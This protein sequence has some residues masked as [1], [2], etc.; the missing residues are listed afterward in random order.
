MFFGALLSAILST[1]SGALLA[2][3]ALFT[4]NVIKPLFGEHERQ[5]LPAACCASCWCSSRPACWSS[6]STTPAPCT[7]WCRTHTRSRSSAP[8][9]RWSAAST[10]NAPPRRARCS[11]RWWASRCGRSARP[12]SPTPLVPPQIV[13]LVRLG[14]RHGRGLA[15][16]ADHARR[17]RRDPRQRPS[18]GRFTPPFPHFVAF[19]FLGPGAAPKVRHVDRKPNRERRRTKEKR[20]ER[21]YRFVAPAQQS[22]SP[23]SSRASSSAWFLLR[24]QRA[25]L[26][27]HAV[28][29][30]TLEDGRRPR[31]PAHAQPSRTSARR[32]IVEPAAAPHLSRM[33]LRA[34][35]P[36]EGKLQ[37]KPG[38]GRAFFSRRIRGPE[39]AFRR[40]R[41]APGVNVT[42]RLEVRVSPPGIAPA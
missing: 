9:C 17:A 28:R 41:F 40:N 21:T 32:I 11:R 5:A 22:P 25:I 3:T 10:G 37:S 16:P 24:R 39:C 19:P 15:R 7:R 6:R 29:A 26:A 14:D 31:R 23:Q 30:A 20:N 34:L 12:S 1:A 2:P 38:S 27:D 18:G 42:F 13:G 4:E 35:P 33:L 36:P 8:S